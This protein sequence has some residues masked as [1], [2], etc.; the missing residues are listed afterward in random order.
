MGVCASRV[1]PTPQSPRSKGHTPNSLTTQSVSIPTSKFIKVQPSMQ[2]ESGRRN[3]A[4]VKRRDTAEQEVDKQKA[5]EQ[6][7]QGQGQGQTLP[8]SPYNVTVEDRS[9]DP[10]GNGKERVG[11][12][13]SSSSSSSDEDDEASEGLA[14]LNAS[15]SS[16]LSREV[17]SGP[18]SPGSPGRHRFTG[19]NE[20]IGAPPISI[21]VATPHAG[22]SAANKRN[23]FRFASADEASFRSNRPV[24]TPGGGSGRSHLGLGTRSARNLSRARMTPK[25]VPA[26]HTDKVEHKE[27]EDTGC[28]HVNQ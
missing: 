28:E 24:V 2:L 25:H 14:P 8:G 22:T 4:P 16:R 7:E 3:P 6:Q 26:K 27:D 19:F 11:D 13:S 20:G 21:K 17:S 9:P 18:E 12:D 15:F 23:L 1:E 10:E 5:D